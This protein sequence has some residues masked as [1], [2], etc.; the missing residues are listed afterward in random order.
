MRVQ[1]EVAIGVLIDPFE[2]LARSRGEDLIQLRAEFFHFLRLDV[3]VRGGTD[4][5]AGDE[6]LVDEHARMWVE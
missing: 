5:A 4:E 3:N 2:R 1:I 6:R